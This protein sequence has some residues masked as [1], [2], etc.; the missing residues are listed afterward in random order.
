M[1][2][3]KATEAEPTT[4]EATL[5]MKH[6][7]RFVAMCSEG[8]MHHWMLKPSNHAHS[9]FS[10]GDV[11]F[12]HFDKVSGEVYSMSLSSQDGLSAALG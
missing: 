6:P 10:D 12:V 3:A 8:L 7:E 9:T 2:K 11:V 1:A 4:V 5:I